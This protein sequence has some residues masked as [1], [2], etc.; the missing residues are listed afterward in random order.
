LNGPLQWEDESD[1]EFPLAIGNDG[2]PVDD[3]AFVVVPDEPT[4][5]GRAVAVRAPVESIAARALRDKQ[6]TAIPLC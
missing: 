3:R 4:A 2:V 5:A 1:A 6:Q